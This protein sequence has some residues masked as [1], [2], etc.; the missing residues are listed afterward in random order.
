M[1]VADGEMKDD[2]TVIM[3]GGEGEGKFPG[4]LL[5]DGQTWD[6]GFSSV[7]TF[8]LFS[9]LEVVGLLSDASLEQ[10]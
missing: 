6:T 9:A 5:S 3:G 1:V 8:G 7:H 4:V 10:A 2:H